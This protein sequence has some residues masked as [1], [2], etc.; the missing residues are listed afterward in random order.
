[1]AYIS[2]KDFC[3]RHCVD[4]SIQEDYFYCDDLIAEAISLLNKNGYTTKYCCSGHWFPQDMVLRKAKYPSDEEIRK[5]NI[6]S[7]TKIEDQNCKRPY[8][9]VSRRNQYS[10]FYVR[11]EEGITIDVSHLPEYFEVD[12]NTKDYIDI[13]L[14]EKYRDQRRISRSYIYKINKKFL[15]FV[16]EYIDETGGDE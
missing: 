15:K 5:K 16:K 2:K 6:I 12:P 1:M 14:K 4:E 3:I 9:C 13:W 7:I 10:L 8:V 11:F